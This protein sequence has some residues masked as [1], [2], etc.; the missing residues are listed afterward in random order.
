MKP[1]Q[2][3]QKSILD[4]LAVLKVWYRRMNS[5]VMAGEYKGKRSFVRFGTPGMADIL[6]APLIQGRPE[7]LWIEVK[8]PKGK[9]SEAQ[10]EFQKE[11]EGGGHSYLIAKSIDDVEQW[12]KQKGVV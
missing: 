7:F 9:Q 5:G 11:V 6:A 12:L 1:E 10:A 2:A 8:A 3:I 4:Y